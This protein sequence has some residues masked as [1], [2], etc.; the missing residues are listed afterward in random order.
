MVALTAFE[1]RLST[2]AVKK[3]EVRVVRG[4]SGVSGVSGLYVALW[5]ACVVVV[6]VCVVSCLCL[7]LVR[8]G[9]Q[10]APLV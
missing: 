1:S 3:L 2:C 7:F 10:Q 9:V 4:W 8:V 6:V 5:G